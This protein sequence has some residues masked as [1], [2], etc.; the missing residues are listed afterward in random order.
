MSSGGSSLSI[1]V[2][3]AA[4]VASSRAAAAH[5]RVD[6]GQVGRVGDAQQHERRR[7]ARAVRPERDDRGRA[8]LRVVAIARA[9][10]VEGGSTALLGGGEADGGDQLIVPER[11]LVGPAEELARGDRARRRAASAPRSS[12]RARRRRPS[13]RPRR[14]RTRASRRP[15]R[16]GASRGSRRT[17]APRGSA[18][19][20]GRRRGS[21]S[22]RL[23]AH[24]RADDELAVALLDRVEARDAVDVDERARLDAAAAS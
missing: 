7:G 4:S 18:A 21:S 11:S 14:R 10:L 20:S 24:E 12:R 8:D 23:L 2:V 19:T 17:A 5:D 13:A 6:V 9:D 1:S 22:R 3:T 16:G 15:C